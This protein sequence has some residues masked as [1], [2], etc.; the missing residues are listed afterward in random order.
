MTHLE[1]QQLTRGKEF[2][3]TRTGK[4]VTRTQVYFT[5]SSEEIRMALMGH[6]GIYMLRDKE[7][8]IDGVYFD[9]EKRTRIGEKNVHPVESQE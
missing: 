9:P 2:V 7:N 8:W 3:S 5:S 6:E 1:L 4:V